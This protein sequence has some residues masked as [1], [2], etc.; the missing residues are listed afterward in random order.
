MDCVVASSRWLWQAMACER[1]E[2][3]DMRIGAEAHSVIRVFSARVA[4]SPADRA[5]GKPG[6]GSMSWPSSCISPV[7]PTRRTSS[8]LHYQVASCLPVSI[9]FSLQ[10]LKHPFLHFPISIRSN[11]S[12]FTSSQHSPLYIPHFTWYLIANRAPSKSTSC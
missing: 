2:L 5:Q 3:N 10:P 11:I 6:V 12:L 9:P 1:A 7:I 4:Q 8:G